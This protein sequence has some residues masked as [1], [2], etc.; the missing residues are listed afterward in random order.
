[1]AVSYIKSATGTGTGSVVLTFASATTTNNAI[2]IQVIGPTSYAT[3]AGFTAVVQQ[4]NNGV[5]N[6]HTLLVGLS[7]GQTTFTVTSAGSSF[8]TVVELTGNATTSYYEAN[9][10][11]TNAATGT[12]ILSPSITTTDALGAVVGSIASSAI[13]L[14]QTSWTNFTSANTTTRSAIGYYIPNAFLT[15]YTTTYTATTSKIMSSAYV[16]IKS[17]AVYKTISQIG[18]TITATGNLQS[19]TAVDNS[20]RLTQVGATLTLTGNTQ[21]INAVSSVSIN[22]VSATLTLQGRNN[23]HL[24]SIPTIGPSSGLFGGTYFA[25]SYFADGPGVKYI[26]INQTSA[27]LTLTT[28]YNQ[29]LYLTQPTGIGAGLYGGAYFGQPYFADAPYGNASLINISQVKATL[30]FTGGTQNV[31][32]NSG[33]VTVKNF[34]W[35]IDGTPVFRTSKKQTKFVETID[36]RNVLK[37]GKK[38]YM[39]L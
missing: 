24:F 14:A 30:T 29:Q 17:P 23:Q 21:T 36:G 8:A 6:F 19:V 13:T 27:T 33:V 25:Q 10:G 22:Q 32:G 11:V 38:L 37:V 2:V 28:G 39:Q 35:L 16:Y 4:P 1:M 12:T 15:N 26:A 9:G 7:T 18:A 5:T 3:L 20:V 31:I 34:V